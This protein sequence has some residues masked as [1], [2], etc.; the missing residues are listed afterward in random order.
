M[1]LATVIPYLVLA[2]HIVFGFV[3]LALIFRNSWGREVIAFV[4]KHSLVIGV[5]VSLATVLGSL[6]YSSVMG[7]PPCELCWWQRVFLFPTLILFIVG[8]KR[9]DKSVFSY[10]TPLALIALVIALYQTL[11]QTT[12]LS[13]L[14]CTAVGGACSKVY[15]NAFG[16]ITIP[17]MGITSAAYLL[18]LSFINRGHE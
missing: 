4:R 9:G 11:S 3:V 12:G 5:F 2:S 14:D 1:L 15:V 7:Y 6:F 16:Y 13:L 8:W 17:V 18:L 10:V